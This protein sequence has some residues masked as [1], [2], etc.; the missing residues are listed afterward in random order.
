MTTTDIKA[1]DSKLNTYRAGPDDQGFFGLFGGRYVAE[2]LMP[3]LLE[4]EAAYRKLRRDR[5]F[6]REVRDYLR[7]YAGRETPLY[8][9]ARLTERLGEGQPGRPPLLYVPGIDVF[10]GSEDLQAWMSQIL[11]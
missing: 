2:T 6:T 10:C 8:F 3:A 11:S 9:A 5:D 1:L 7:E 4:L